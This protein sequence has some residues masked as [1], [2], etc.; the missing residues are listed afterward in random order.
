MI[1][2]Q[3]SR[4][5]EY[6]KLWNNI[7]YLRMDHQKRNHKAG[8]AEKHIKVCSRKGGNLKFCHSQVCNGRD[9]IQLTSNCH[10]SLI[11]SLPFLFFSFLWK[12]TDKTNISKCLSPECS[13]GAKK[14]NQALS[15]SS[16]SLSVTVK[17]MCKTTLAQ[18]FRKKA[19][20]ELS[21]NS[22]S[23]NYVGSS[24]NIIVCWNLSIHLV[25]S[26]NQSR[27]FVQ[28]QTAFTWI[29]LNADLRLNHIP[30]LWYAHQAIY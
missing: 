8:Q 16:Q 6:Q 24:H 22:S 23:L 11:I 5:L 9:K 12:R 3:T 7:Q 4:K 1:T 28:D 30:A 2:Y 17:L 18:S 21:I 14:M 13:T 10:Q 19:K 25:Q 27:I 15:R 20:A 29:F 26:F